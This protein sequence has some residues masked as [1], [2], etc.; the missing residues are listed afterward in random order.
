MRL[1]K[2]GI[3]ASMGSVG[4]CYDNAMMESFWG[5]LQLEVLDQ[6]TWPNARDLNVLAGQTA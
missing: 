5:T 6:G 1:L 2:S 4:D 3:L